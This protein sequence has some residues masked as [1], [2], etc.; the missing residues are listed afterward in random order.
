MDGDKEGSGEKALKI[1]NYQL[2]IENWPEE[3]P[4]RGGLL[5]I[6]NF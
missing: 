6:C 1:E 3:R 5:P 2:K 4:A